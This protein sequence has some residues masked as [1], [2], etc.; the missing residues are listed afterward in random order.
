M[1]VINFLKPTLFF[2][3]FTTIL[4]CSSTENR[5]ESESGKKDNTAKQADPL[6]R[7]IKVH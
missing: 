5:K 7:G 6:L 4:S 2:A 3:P 1:N